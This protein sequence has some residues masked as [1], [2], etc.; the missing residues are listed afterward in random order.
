MT[1]VCVRNDCAEFL[2]SGG[3]P[4]QRGRKEC[5]NCLKTQASRNIVRF[6]N[7][8][9]LSIFALLLAGT[10]GAHA[11]VRA[12]DWNGPYLGG[13]LG[14][15]RSH[16][17]VSIRDPGALNASPSL[18]SLFGGLQFGYNYVSPSSRVLIG[19]EADISFPNSYTSDAEVWAGTTPRSILVEQLDYIATLRGRLGYAFD[20]TLFYATAGL[21]IS[22]G[23]FVRT[24]PISGDEQSRPG[25]RAGFT[26]GGGIEYALQENWSA[27]FEYLYSRFGSTS[28]VFANGATYA[29]SFDI[30]TVRVG[31][32]RK[33]GDLG[34]G[35]SKA[36][37]S[38]GGWSDSD[39]WEIRGQTTYVQQGYP[40]FRAAY[41]GENS[42]PT[43]RQTKQ[44]IL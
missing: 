26:V 42:L 21:A 15:G 34:S 24:D 23:H 35:A 6:S 38:V 31:L 9:C 4:E 8:F 20:K 22:S 19:V 37:E 39:Q 33:F 36:R 17:D 14:Y 1:S 44:S 5:R 16:G 11:Q 25:M 30:N 41:S 43:W 2:Q 3:D 40:S 18:G 10:E 29:S 7:V 13:H 12:F 28:T 27:R 32:N